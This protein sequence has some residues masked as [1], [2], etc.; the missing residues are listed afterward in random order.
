ME[1]Y[2]PMNATRLSL[3]LFSLSNILVTLSATLLFPYL[4]SKVLAILVYAQY[5][6]RFPS[7]EPAGGLDLRGPVGAGRLIKV[8]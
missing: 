5:L 2:L 7:A 3:Y 1:E 8:R 4:G 6:S